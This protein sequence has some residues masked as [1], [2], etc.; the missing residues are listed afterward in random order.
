MPRHAR[1]LLITT[2]FTLLTLGAAAPAAANFPGSNGQIAFQ[3]F[4]ADGYWQIWVANPDLTHQRQITDG[5]FGSGFAAW[6]PD[7]SRIAFQSDR[8]DP[9]IT[10][11]FEIQDVFTMRPDGS[12]VRKLTDSLGFSGHPSY[13]PDGRW[14]VFDADRA[15]YPAAMGIYI[16]PSDGSAPPRRVTILVAPSFW[17]ELAR[18]SPDGSRIVWDEGRGGKVLSHHQDGRL[19]AEQT[20]LFS[21]RVDGTD[22]RQVTPW[23][24][25]AVDPDWSPDGK[26]LVFASQPTRIGDIGEVM[27]ADANGSHLRTLTQDAGLIGIGSDNAF[28]YSEAFNPV[29]SPD[30]EKILF[31]HASFTVAAGFEMGL[32]TVNPDGTGR[33]WVSSLRFEEH[34]PEWG[35]L[36]ALP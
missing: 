26:R 10:D 28:V 18:F 27:V 1:R 22:L 30:G 2:L 23:G 16:I 3:R 9:D 17:Q 11:G 19:V 12:D 14:I 6:S 34:Q 31:V 24:L 15:N 20:A 33:A 35:T 25:H 36:A 8:S 4:D 5:A 21:A 7:G 32:Q 29:W 13:S